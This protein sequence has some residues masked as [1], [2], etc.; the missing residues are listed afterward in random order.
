MM[1]LGHGQGPR[2]ADR[3]PLGTRGRQPLLLAVAGPQPPWTHTLESAV[4]RVPVYHKCRR[5]R[6][7]NLPR[8]SAGALN[9]LG[10]VSSS[11]SCTLEPHLSA[12]PE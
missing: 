7:A 12:G 9:L 2:R 5:A 6:K 4:L 10:G 11:R 1:T 3:A 8:S